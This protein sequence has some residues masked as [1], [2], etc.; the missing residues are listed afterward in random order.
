MILIFVTKELDR[1]L[2]LLLRNKIEFSICCCRVRSCCK[3]FYE[4][5]LS[6]Y[7]RYSCSW[8]YLLNH[9]GPYSGSTAVL[10]SKVSP[11]NFVI[12]KAKELPKKSKER[13]RHTVQ[14]FPALAMQSF[15]RV[16][17]DGTRMMLV[18]IYCY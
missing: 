5:N 10:V 1:I 3:S 16:R 14:F 15:E 2:N 12:D 17:H 6:D 7:C 8:C 9:P 13:L 11:L 18:I 4:S